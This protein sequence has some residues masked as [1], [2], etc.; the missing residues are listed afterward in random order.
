M[1]CDIE[2]LLHRYRYAELSIHSLPVDQQ[3]AVLSLMALVESL[4]SGAYVVTLLVQELETALGRHDFAVVF[5]YA[6]KLH[7]GWTRTTWTR[8]GPLLVVVNRG[9]LQDRDDLLAGPYE[10]DPGQE[11]ELRDYQEALNELLVVRSQSD[12]VTIM[13]CAEVADAVG[14]DADDPTV[15]TVMRIERLAY[16]GMGCLYLTDEQ[17]VLVPD[18]LA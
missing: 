3:K 8:R 6:L 11:A 12:E 14:L 1:N 9:G 16:T 10:V 18:S 15:R 17:L 5:E 2:T 4:A 13:T 7:R